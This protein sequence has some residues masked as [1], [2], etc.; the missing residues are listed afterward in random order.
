MQLFYYFLFYYEN[1][2]LKCIF[3]HNAD[4]MH[5]FLDNLKM[6]ISKID[7]SGVGLLARKVQ[8]RK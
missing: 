3:P 6:D 5:I 2:A 4:R 1:L 7:R 8:H